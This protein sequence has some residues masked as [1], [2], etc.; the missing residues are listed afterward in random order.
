MSFAM[1]AMIHNTSWVTAH[2]HL[3]FG[4][5]VV[6]VYFAIAY[7]LW[8]R[9]TGRPLV[10]KSLACRQLWLWFWGILI[11]TVPWHIAGL[12]GQ[13]R[14]YALFDYSDPV[15]AKTAPLDIISVAGGVVLVCSVVLFFYVLV[16]SSLS[17]VAEFMPP[18]R[19]ALAVN[20]PESVPRLLN[21]FGF[22]NIILLL[23]VLISYG[24]PIGQFFFLHGQD[25]PGYSLTREL[26]K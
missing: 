3:I 9:L 20:P 8:P 19:Y 18:V 10:S 23:L 4:G 26:V 13:P 12:M 1:N 2:F 15:V 14:R 6:I 5:A 21:G 24:Y 7:E 17:P 11:T 16:R 22:W 25:A